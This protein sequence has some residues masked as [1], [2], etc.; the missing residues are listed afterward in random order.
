MYDYFFTGKAQK[1]NKQPR[2][3]NPRDMHAGPT[4]L[5]EQ[6]EFP[7]MWLQLQSVHVFPE[8]LDLLLDLLHRVQLV[9][10][11]HHVALHLGHL[12]LTRLQRPGELVQLRPDLGQR[13]A[14]L[15]V[16]AVLGAVVRGGRAGRHAARLKLV[17]PRC[18]VGA[19]VRH[20]V[21]QAA[22]TIHHVWARGHT[23]KRSRAHRYPITDI[24]IKRDGRHVIIGMYII[25]GFAYLGVLLLLLSGNIMHTRRYVH[26]LGGGV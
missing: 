13:D 2:T 19:H 8:L 21:L 5:F 12:R 3:S 18:Q 25:Y 11:G 1:T 26:F 22:Q 23:H 14:G 24:W 4:D 17:Q 10:D 9:L 7:A 16:A 6:S 15:H 20:L